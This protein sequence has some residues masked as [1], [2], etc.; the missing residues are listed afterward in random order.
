MNSGSLREALKKHLP[1]LPKP[2]I[3]SLSLLLILV[4]TNQCR[5]CSIKIVC[6]A[7]QEIFYKLCSRSYLYANEIG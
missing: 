7:V 6:T 4:D 5:I 3:A 1:I 2:L